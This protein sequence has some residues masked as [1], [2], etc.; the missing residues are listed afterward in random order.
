MESLT[1]H[2]DSRYEDALINLEQI[3]AQGFQQEENLRTKQSI[4][5]FW[6]KVCSLI[7]KKSWNTQ[8][9]LFNIV[10][11]LYSRVH[12]WYLHIYLAIIILIQLCRVSGV[13]LSSEGKPWLLLS[14]PGGLAVRGWGYSVMVQGIGGVCICFFVM[15]S[16]CGRG[17][18]SGGR[19]GQWVLQDPNSVT[20]WYDYL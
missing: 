17:L 19:N 3:F 12:I 20:S 6:Q 7:S 2:P 5:R 15:F 8:V 10:C 9:F 4:N 16:W 13:Q 1:R 14:V 18:I 11:A